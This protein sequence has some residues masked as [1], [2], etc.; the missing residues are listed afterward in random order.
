MEKEISATEAVR[1]FSEVLSSVLYKGAHYRIVR[2]GKP[3]ASISPV[4]RIEEPSTLSQL[5]IQL[6]RL[7][8]LGEDSL[9]FEKDLIAVRDEQPPLPEKPS[10]E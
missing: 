10:W 1:R 9:A 4:A 5:K 7:P 3:V 2:G 8:K 6:K